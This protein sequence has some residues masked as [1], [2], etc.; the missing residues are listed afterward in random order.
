M[1]IK[2]F[3]IALHIILENENILT[4]FNVLFGGIILNSI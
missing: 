3:H 4:L 1:V 2:G